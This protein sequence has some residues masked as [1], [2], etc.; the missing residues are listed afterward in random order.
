MILSHPIDLSSAVFPVLTF[1]DQISLWKGGYA[2]VD[3]YDDGG[4][5]SSAKMIQRS[6]ESIY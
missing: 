5:R 1:W 3:V 2:G 6:G 4:F